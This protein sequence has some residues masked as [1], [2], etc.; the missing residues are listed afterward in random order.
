M[1]AT[2]KGGNRGVRRGRAMALRERLLIVAAVVICAAGGYG[3]LRIKAKEAEIRQ[4]SAEMA[5]LEAEVA[6]A[7]APRPAGSDLEE[8]QAAL[9]AARK[10]LDDT[11]AKLTEQTQ[12]MVNLGSSDALETV[13]LELTD[14]AARYR[15]EVQQSEAFTAT[16]AGMPT[17]AAA[18][19][20]T[21]GTPPAA[22]GNV[23]AAP[24]QPL[25][26]RPMRRLA[27]AGRYADLSRFLESLDKMSN[28]V[29]VLS[30][31]MKVTETRAAASAGSPRL[32]AELVVML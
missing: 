1:K 26:G 14:L 2:A 28:K 10:A 30:L 3:F 8:A 19:D 24:R 27:L 23:A 9:D 29:W 31:A 5:R 16:V 11:N 15:I 17:I 21:P 18:A 4:F 25:S 6:A 12:N 32:A 22:S 13:M 20:G 7:K